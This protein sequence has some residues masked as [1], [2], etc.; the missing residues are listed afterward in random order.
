[1]KRFFLFVCLLASSLLGVAQ[2][3][4][5][6]LEQAY[7]RLAND[8]QAKYGMVSL[9]VLNAKTGQTIFAKNEN[10]GVP[11]A[12]TLK[13]ITAA[14]AFGL[15]G[16]DFQ[17]ETKLAYTGSIA[18]GVLRGD[19]VIVGSGDPTLGASRYQS[20][21]ETVVL[22]KFY[23]AIKQL[24]I[25][26]IDGG[27][28][29]DDTLF[30]TQTVPDSWI[31]Q[32]IGNYY[33]AGSG[34]LAWN[35]NQFDI[36][37]TPG[38][39]VGQVVKMPKENGNAPYLKI[40]NELTTGAAGSGDNAYAYLPPFADVAYLRGTWGIDIKKKSIGAA[41]PDAAYHLA[42]C[43]QEYLK[44]Q[45]VGVVENATTARKM[46]LENQQIAGALKIIAAQ[47]SP[48]LAE[49]VYW[50]QKKSIN[51][52]GEQLL[53]TMALKAGKTPTTKNGAATVIGFWADKGIDK[54]ALNI[55]DGSGL[56]PATRVP[57]ATMAKILYW[58]KNQPWFAEYYKSFP[59]NN[60]M[61]IKSGTI[62]DV[63]AFAGYFNNYIVVIN[64]SNYNG[65]GINKKIFATLDALK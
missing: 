7:Q 21:S 36:E 56:S 57:V 31:W 52:Y 6:K 47:P 44:K 60:G 38:M 14:T 48:R 51:L 12:S 61:K 3:V 8:S 18:D 37:L 25:K 63:S 46:A 5:A 1:M 29:G 22:K 9:C 16:A 65:T 35:E 2:S 39:A 15:L 27:I 28:I 20:N 26:K 33:G 19:M 53:K 17:F 54:N 11:T 4:V 50:F 58:A 32:D 40:V 10:V 13:T 59:E 55:K 62:N 43:L 45:G 34:A 64:M 49:I 42:F 41:L 23:E 30:G 24:G